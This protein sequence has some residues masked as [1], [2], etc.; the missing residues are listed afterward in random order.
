MFQKCSTFQTIVIILMVTAGAMFMIDLK[1]SDEIPSRNSIGK[2]VLFSHPLLQVTLVFLANLLC[3]GV[4]YIQKGLQRLDTKENLDDMHVT[5]ELYF[6][7]IFI[8]IKIATEE[9]LKT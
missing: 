7:L 6:D 9:G 5:C 4:F 1:W 8:F 2:K 3:L